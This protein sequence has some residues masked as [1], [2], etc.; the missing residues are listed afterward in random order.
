MAVSEGLWSKGGRFLSMMFLF[1]VM[2]LMVG[3][4]AH[5][6]KTVLGYKVPH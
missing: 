1:T 6:I 2:L 5:E 4:L 3:K